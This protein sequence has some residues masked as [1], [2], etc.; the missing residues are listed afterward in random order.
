MLVSGNGDGDDR[1]GD[2]AAADDEAAADGAHMQEPPE[3]HTSEHS[4]EVAGGARLEDEVLGLNWL[5]FVVCE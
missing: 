4:Q 1:D 3:G 5:P 2:M